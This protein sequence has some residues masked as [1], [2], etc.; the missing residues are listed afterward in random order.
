MVVSF[1]D[2]HAP[3][4]FPREWR[5][6]YRP[7]QFPPRPSP[8]EI[9]SSSPR[10]FRDLTRDDFRGIQAAY[11]TSLSFMDFQVGRLIQALED[12]GL[13][14]D[15]LVVFLSDNGYL[16]GQH[17]RVEKNCF[18]EPAVRVPLIVRW[19][20]HLPQGKRVL[21]MVELVDLFPTVCSLLKVPAPPALHGMDLAPLIE[22]KPGAKGRD[23]VFSEY[24]ES[25]EAMV[26]SDRYKLIV[27]TGRRERK[28]HLEIGR[29]LSG[30]LSSPVRPQARPGR[31]VNL[32]GAPA[33]RRGPQRVAAQNAPAPGCPRGVGPEPIPAG[34]SELETIHWCLTPRDKS[35]AGQIA[36]AVLS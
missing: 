22:G 16:L 33:V 35:A 11:Y 13:G 9:A 25:E 3:F 21:E 5:G 14:S 19:P 10:S 2:P 18:Y 7:E 23:V 27:G 24:N 12:S 1:Y 30:P 6:R 20:G 4:R 28:D 17:G 34:L 31:D 26:R 15:T 8:S 32:S 36:D 29:P